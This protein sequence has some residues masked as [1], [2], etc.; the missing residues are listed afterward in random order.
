MGITVR[1]LSPALGAEIS[2]F[3]LRN[4]D[5]TTAKE[6]LD[7]WHQYLVLLVRGQS[8]SDDDHIN[9]TKI[10]GEIDPAKFTGPEGRPEIMLISN[11]REDGKPIGALPD[12]EMEFHIDRLHQKVPSAGAVLHAIE[13]PAEGGN[14][15]YLNMYL[16]YETLPAETKKRIEGLEAVSF[17]DYSATK[18]V[19]SQVSPDTPSAVHPVVRIHPVTKRKSLFVCGLMT[20]HIVGLP[21]EESRKILSELYKH[22]EQ[23]GFVY[24]HKWKVGDIIIWDNR[25]TM[26]ARTDFDFSARRL[27]KRIA[28]KGTPV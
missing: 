27:I 3:D 12:G 14:T 15:L 5:T 22:S 19:D 17:Y 9:F 11:I 26:H 28:I 1:P 23:S 10:F 21:K 7:A 13:V 4:I 2:G 24:E 6:I 16:A 8:I 18:R 20:D 25:C